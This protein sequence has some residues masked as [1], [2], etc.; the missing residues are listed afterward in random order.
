LGA[1][2][3]PNTDN[4]HNQTFTVGVQ[5]G[6]V[7]IALLYAM[8]VVHLWLFRRKDWLCWVALVTVIQN[9]IASLTNSYLF[10]FTAAWTYIFLVGVLGGPLLNRGFDR[11]AATLQ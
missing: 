11:T 9:V 2:I 7:G 1:N 5:L 3:I 4:P 10:D 8:W 6:L